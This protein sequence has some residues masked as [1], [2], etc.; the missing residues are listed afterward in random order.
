MSMRSHILDIET[1]SLFSAGSRR[2]WPVPAPR[3]KRVE[4]RFFYDVAEHHT[5]SASTKGDAGLEFEL[6]VAGSYS[7]YSEGSSLSR[8]ADCGDAPE[9]RSN[10]Q[11]GDH[12][13]IVIAQLGDLFGVASTR[14]IQIRPAYR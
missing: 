2:N 5:S 14:R 13:I 10:R 11:L 1:Y 3:I 6:R 12:H 7:S 4:I 9:N 8:V